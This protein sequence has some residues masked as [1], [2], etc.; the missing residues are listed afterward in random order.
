M[1]TPNTSP[2]RHGDRCAVVLRNVHVGDGVH[3]DR[4]LYGNFRGW[5]FGDP[6]APSKGFVQY[7]GSTSGRNAEVF[8]IRPL[9]DAE[10][11][12]ETAKLEADRIRY[13]F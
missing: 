12:A 9:T 7:D 2:L 1:T 4:T 3:V 6:N 8:G 10:V 11:A 13:D 5:T